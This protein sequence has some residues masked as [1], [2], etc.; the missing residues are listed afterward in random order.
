MKIKLKGNITWI[1]LAGLLLFGGVGAYVATKGGWFVPVAMVPLIAAAAC[2]IWART[3]EPGKGLALPKL[4]V[5]QWSAITG[6]AVLAVFFGARVIEQ[7]R[8]AEDLVQL[9]AVQERSLAEGRRQYEEWRAKM[10]EG[11]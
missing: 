7:R 11:R 9:K 8:D 3:E 1:G 6:A 10:D 5:W 4:P 2:V